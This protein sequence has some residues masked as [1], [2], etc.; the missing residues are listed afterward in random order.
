MF[1]LPYFAV[2]FTSELTQDTAGY[3]EMA[4]RMEALAKQQPGYLGI[5]HARDTLGITISYWQDEAAIAQWKTQIEHLEAQEKGKRQWYKHYN[6]QVCKVTR[7]YQGGK[8]DNKLH[9]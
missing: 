4:E 2:I 7:A 5:H 8:G 1:K 9:P 6:V 3:Q